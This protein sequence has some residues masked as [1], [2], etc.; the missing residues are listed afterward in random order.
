MRTAA[1]TLLLIL[2]VALA[3]RAA[4][5]AETSH[6]E[7]VSEYIREL[8]AD[9]DNRVQAVREIAE[10]NGDKNSAIIRGS[11]RIILEL[12]SEI[13]I[14]KGMT[15]NKPFDQL[16]NSIAAFYSQKID[17]H[18]SMVTIATAFMSGPKSGVDYGAMAADAAKLRAM[19]EYIDSSLLKATPMIF[20]TLIDERPDSEGHM[21]RLIITK[22]QRDDL[23]R[24]LQ[25][26][27][28]NKLDDDRQ[29]NFTIS[30]ASVLRDY[31]SKKGYKCLDEPL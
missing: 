27:F 3:P 15:L 16:P 17:A 2:S 8:G 22:A 25:I 5:A 21:S 18:H 20:A 1:F 7:F 28:D 19:I 12:T 14:L 9:E 11:T 26:R 29:K 4:L 30:S 24:S 13:S 10:Q 31:L 6:L 23:V